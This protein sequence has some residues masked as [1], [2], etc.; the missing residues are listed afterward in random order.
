MK[1]NLDKTHSYDF[2]WTNKQL[3][4]PDKIPQMN[5]TKHIKT[6]SDAECSQTSSV[7]D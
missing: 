4:K 6:E 2:Y 5:K 3:P 1:Q 7:F